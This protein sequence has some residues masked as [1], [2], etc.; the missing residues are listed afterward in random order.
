VQD[1]RS[2]LQRYVSESENRENRVK[3]DT[4]AVGIVIDGEV[5]IIH[6]DFVVLHLSQKDICKCGTLKIQYLT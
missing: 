6:S 3:T 5:C 2:I 1:T 4:C